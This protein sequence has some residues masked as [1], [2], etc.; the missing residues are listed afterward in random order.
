MWIDNAT[1]FL[2]KKVCQVADQITLDIDLN[3]LQIVV[4]KY[5]RQ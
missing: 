1:C 5:M 3:E 2:L 4:R